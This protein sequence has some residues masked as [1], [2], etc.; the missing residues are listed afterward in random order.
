MFNNIGIELTTSKLSNR[1][2]RF[3]HN[4]FALFCFACLNLFYQFCFCWSER[5]KKLFYFIFVSRIPKWWHY[6]A[7]VHK[8]RYSNTAYRMNMNNIKIEIGRCNGLAYK[9]KSDNIKGK[10]REIKMKQTFHEKPIKIICNA[11]NSMS[12]IF[13][14]FF[15]HCNFEL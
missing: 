14:F 9:S 4:N 10:L 11:F 5:K 7:N 1:P 6:L 13:F 2:K 12:A 3:I 15:W 8:H